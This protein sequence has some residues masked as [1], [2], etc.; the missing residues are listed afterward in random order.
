MAGRRLTAELIEGYAEQ[1]R[2][3]ERAEATV[4]KY[5][6]A[7]R[8]YE[9][10]LEGREVTR[11][12]TAAWKEHLTSEG[13]E[14]STVNGQLSALDGLYRWLGWT[15]CSVRHIRVQ[16]RAF[17]ES[18]RELSRGEYERLIGSARAAGRVR[19]ALVM[20]TL[21]A[22]G[23]RVSEL[24][25]VTVEALE[26]G[27]AEVWLKGKVRTILLP[28]KLSRKLLK[29]AK[30]RGISRGEVFVTATGRSLSRK[31]VWQEMK[32]EC[33]RAGVESGKVFPHN[34]R[35]LFARCFYEASRDVTKLADVL[36]HSS[37]DTTRIY[38]MT[39]FTEHE[40]FLEA[41][42]LVS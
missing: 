42:S 39:S 33:A 14:P 20:E 40:R 31:Q 19:L 23:I 6:R 36:G 15:D 32:K 21:G 4:E 28:S 34:L 8:Q 37:I 26:Q 24:R 41:L 35:H 13:R 22:T 12:L 7:L 9:R 10:W 29:Y 3:D 25:Y 5:M 27:R 11:E 30:S 16:R 2:R 18:S 17:C 38:L 1:L